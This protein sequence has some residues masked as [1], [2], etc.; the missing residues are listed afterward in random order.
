MK[1]KKEA[2]FYD[3]AAKPLFTS[4]QVYQWL[5]HDAPFQ[6]VDKITHLDDTSVIG[7]KNITINEPQFTG[8]FKNNPVFPGVLIIETIAQV[9]GI[10]VLNTV[11]DPDNYWTYLM[12]V[13]KCKFRRMVTPGDTIVIKCE[14][15]R[16]ISRGIV[17]M[18]G[19]AYVNG[20]LVCETEILASI[21]KKDK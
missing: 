9:G 12:G 8:H 18:S 15:L 5:P 10:Y 7:I 3:P 13:E 16:P 17:N 21:V 14:L 2:P 11:P 19:D 1:N 6:L 20:V 4:T